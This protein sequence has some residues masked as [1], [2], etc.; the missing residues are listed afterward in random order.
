MYSFIFNKIL[1]HCW[2]RNSPLAGQPW[3]TFHT[4]T[5]IKLKWVRMERVTVWVGSLQLLSII[6]H[7]PSRL[8]KE[9]RKDYLHLASFSGGQNALKALEE[10]GRRGNWIE[11]LSLEI[12]HAWPVEMPSEHWSFIS[13]RKTKT[14]ASSHFWSGESMGK[15]VSYH[16]WIGYTN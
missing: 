1:F 9:K 8:A 2:L 4:V 6:I 5:K 11:C 7:L 10:S 14:K 12:K 13:S 15:L 16:P 3:A